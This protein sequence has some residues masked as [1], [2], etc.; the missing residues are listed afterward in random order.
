MNKFIRL[1]GVFLACNGVATAIQGE[2]AEIFSFK[3]EEKGDF[4]QIGSLKVSQHSNSSSSKQ[5]FKA[6]FAESKCLNLLVV[7][8]LP[9]SI[10]DKIV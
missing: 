9:D 3:I 8:I 6:A 2:E 10:P 7:S 4:G 5:A 1:K